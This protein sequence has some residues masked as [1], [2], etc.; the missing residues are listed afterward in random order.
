MVALPRR[1]ASAAASLPAIA[2]AI[3]PSPLWR[4]NSLPSS[5]APQTF[6][7][8]LSREA[9]ERTC[10]PRPRRPSS[11]PTP[12]AP[13]PNLSQWS[14]T[15]GW[16]C[17]SVRCVPPDLVAARAIWTQLTPPPNSH[18]SENDFGGSQA[19][20]VPPALPLTWYLPPSLTSPSTGAN[21]PGRR[22]LFVSASQRSSIVVE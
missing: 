9:A 14:P 7:S 13:G 19:V 6:S 4:T 21:Q 5:E 16:T 8:K 1:V 15:G 10:M 17:S 12:T 2:G 20:I 3:Q 22:S 18:V 11:Q